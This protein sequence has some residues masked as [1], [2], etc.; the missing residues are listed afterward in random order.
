MHAG[1]EDFFYHSAD[2]LRLH[3]RVYGAGI[4]NRLPV[5]CL[6]GLTRNVRDF[7]ELA[8]YLSRDAETPRKVVAFDY[9]GRGESAYDPDWK[10][11]EVTVEAG[12]VLASLAALGIDAAAFI[13]TSRGG[14]IIHV[15]AA[16]RPAVLKAVVLNDVGPVLEPA[17]LALIKAY[18]AAPQQRPSSWQAAADV[19]RAIHAK[20]FTALAE[21]DWAAMARA[22]YRERNGVLVPD[23]DPALLNGLAGLDLSR[24]LPDLWPQFE[25]M[26]DIPVM[27]IRG[28]NSLL[29][30]AEVLAEM[31]RRHSGLV[32]VTV[33]GQGHAP[34]LHTDGLKQRIEAFL[35]QADGA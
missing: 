8:S 3:A 29:L 2:G 19:Q 17:G 35:G 14:L 6:P 4:A 9:R 26:K 32:A 25:A 13:G 30:S 18:L 12:D 28:A 15:L 33:E 21:E 20:A 10:K 27:A 31:Q 7:H 24:P 1:F 5:V 34:L 22:I 23:F 11:Y 16:I